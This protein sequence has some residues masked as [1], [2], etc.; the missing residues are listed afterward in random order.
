[1]PSASATNAPK[2]QP[3]MAWGPTSVPTNVGIVINGPIP[4]I[5]AMLSAID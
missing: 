3:I 2:I 5:F 4:T 1:M